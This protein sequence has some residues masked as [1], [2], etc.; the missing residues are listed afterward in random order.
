MNVT[1][2][3]IPRPILWGSQLSEKERAEFSWIHEDD[4]DI[5]EF[6][7]YRGVVYCLQDFMRCPESMA[8]WDG[9]HCETFFSA[10]V[11]R[12]VDDRDCPGNRDGVV[13]GRIYS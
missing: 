2:N 10:V 1:T 9:Y 3:N 6:F 7:R 11:L 13:V 12:Y 5:Y 8:P 4:M